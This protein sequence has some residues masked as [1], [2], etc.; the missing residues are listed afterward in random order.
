[1]HI[2]KSNL[3][4]NSQALS[5]GSEKEEM[6]NLK[7]FTDKDSFIA[8]AKALFQKVEQSDNVYGTIPV[9]SPLP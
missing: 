5:I 3:E 4:T 9:V 2:L 8:K 1:M 6:V 7:K